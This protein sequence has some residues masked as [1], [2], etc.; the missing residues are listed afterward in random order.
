M[1]E[2]ALLWLSC[3]WVM[4]LLG[5]IGS[6]DADPTDERLKAEM[7]AVLGYGD[8][9]AMELARDTLAAAVSAAYVE[10]YSG[11]NE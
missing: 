8:I 11:A 1:T 3:Q 9:S 10:V 4:R 5:P 7:A 2:A 6:E